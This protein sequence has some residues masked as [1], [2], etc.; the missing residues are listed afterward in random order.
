MM[1]HDRNSRS[2][3]ITDI[4]SERQVFR[5]RLLHAGEIN[6]IGFADAL[7]AITEFYDCHK[8]DV[9]YRISRED[10]RYLGVTVGGKLVA[11]VALLS[12]GEHILDHLLF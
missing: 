7:A 3:L 1:K 12:K 2:I 11:Q 8:D 5:S 10:P 4:E 6:T 9:D